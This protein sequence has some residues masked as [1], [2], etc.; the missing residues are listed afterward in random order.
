[1][2]PFLALTAAVPLAGVALLVGFNSQNQTALV[3]LSVV[4][5]LGLGVAVWLARRIQRDLADLGGVVRPS[6]AG[7]LSGDTDSR[8][9]ASWG[10]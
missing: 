7:P 3:A 8:L 2:W 9:S 1:V 10:G 4:G 6:D 5:L